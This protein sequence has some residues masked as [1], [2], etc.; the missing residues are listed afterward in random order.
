MKG[1]RLVIPLSLQAEVLTK[2][3]VAHQGIEKTRLRARSCVYWKS[4]SKDIDDIV[5]KFAACQQ[6]QKCQEHEPLIQHELPTRPW[7]IIGTDLF[8][9]GQD[10]TRIYSSVTIIQRPFCIQ[11]QGEGDE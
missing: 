6:L 4:I 8:M 1:D 2:L 10:R 3:H 7:Q 5:R 11:H 9:I